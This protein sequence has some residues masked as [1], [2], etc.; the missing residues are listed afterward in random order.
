MSHPSDAQESD[1]R[2]PLI[3]RVLRNLWDTVKVIIVSVAIIVPIRAYVV[4]PFFV[5]GASMDPSFYDSEYL[6]VEELSYAA[7]LREPRRGDVVVFRYPL[8]RSQHYIKRIIGLPGE[9]VVVRGGAVIIVNRD[10]PSGMHLDEGWYLSPGIITTGTT[11]VTLRNS[12]YFVLGDNRDH[13]SDSRAWGPVSREL[14]IGRA[15]IRVFPV[16]RAGTIP[17]PQYGG[18]AVPVATS[19][20]SLAR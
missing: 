10:Y 2:P 19:L 4:Q 15:W 8:D 14:L 12:E 9:R 1:P 18:L 5:R 7:N 3:Q 11:D 16:A 20:P 6:V 17:A 13:S